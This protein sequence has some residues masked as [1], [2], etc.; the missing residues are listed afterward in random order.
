M[1]Q[2]YKIVI[3]DENDRIVWTAYP[4]NYGS[5]LKLME[6][7]YIGNDLM[8]VV[9]QQLY[10]NPQR[11]VWAGDYAD[12]EPN[13]KDNL[14]TITSN[15]ERSFTSPKNIPTIRY[16]VNHS[17]KQIVGLQRGSTN[18]DDLVIH[19]LSILTAE[20]NGR[21]G[22]DFIGHGPIGE[23]ARDTISTETD[24]SIECYMNDERFKLFVPNFEEI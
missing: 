6:H 9:E 15:Q 17:T 13:G 11:L 12:K 19:P 20:G 4:R 24:E 18:D 16:L 22:G 3:L 23:W 2:Y 5:G 1:G 7:S 10:S 21:G 8:T 14:Y